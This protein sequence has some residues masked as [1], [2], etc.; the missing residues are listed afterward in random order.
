MQFQHEAR[1]ASRFVMMPMTASID[2]STSAE[3]LLMRHL[4]LI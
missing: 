3:T 1:M 2:L 4:V